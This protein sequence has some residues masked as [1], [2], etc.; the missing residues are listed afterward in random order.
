MD[1]SV[2]YKEWDTIAKEW[3]L[4]PVEAYKFMFS[5]VK[6]RYDDILSE[7]VS[8]TDKSIKIL[9]ISI[10]GL[11]VLAGYFIKNND[12]CLG[13]LIPLGMFYFANFALLILLMFPKPVP[14]KGSPPKE[15]F[16]N[17]L[18][19]TTYVADDKISV[20]YYNELIRYQGRIDFLNSENNKRQ[21]NYRA[22]L[23]LTIICIVYTTIIVMQ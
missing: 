20:L 23:V 22:V 13:A 17:S 11:S 16:I 3:D 8:I 15:I 21:E 4:V 14:L 5:Q 10:G 9:T 12:V 1:N 7:S 19:N 6:D 18:D 2:N